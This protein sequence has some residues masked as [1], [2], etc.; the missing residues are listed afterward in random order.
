MITLTRKLKKDAN[1]QNETKRSTIR[2][3]LLLKEVQ[4]LEQDLPSTCKIFYPDS[5]ILSEFVLTITPDEGFW[6]DGKFKFSVAV[7]EEYN[8]MVNKN[9]HLFLDFYLKTVDS[10]NCNIIYMYYSHRR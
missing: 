8:M 3:R 10:I 2:D 9:I 6:K 7:P 4:D 1:N 5:N